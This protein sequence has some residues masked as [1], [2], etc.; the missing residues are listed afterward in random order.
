MDVHG[1]A[2]V[3]LDRLGHEGC[4]AP[5]A[6]RRFAHRALEDEDL[7]GLLHRIAVDEVD[8]E[9][10]RTEFLNDGVDLDPLRG[11]EVVDMVSDALVFV[12]PLHRERLIAALGPARAALRRFQ[13][14][15]GIGVRL[16]QVELQL[17]CDDRLPAQFLEALEHAAQD[18]A[19]GKVDRLTVQIEHVVNHLDRRHRGPGQRARRAQIGLE[20]HVGIRPQLAVRTVGIG[21]GDGRKE[22]RG[23]QAGFDPAEPLLRRHNLAARDTGEIGRVALDFLDALLA[24]PFAKLAHPPRYE[25]G[26]L[27]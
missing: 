20:D 27:F 8:L 10:G 2:R 18:R 9:L 14:Q 25:I 19:R 12:D 6:Q 3:A 4:V 21:A 23:R 13:R 11:G 7:V 26:G 1:V 16:G 17:R 22:N 5:A 24:R 15:V